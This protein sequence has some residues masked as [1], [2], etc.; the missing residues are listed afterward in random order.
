MEL[1][2]YQYANL[3][4]NSNVEAYE[5]GGTFIRVKFYGTS[6]IYTY[7]YNSAGMENVE[8]AKRLAFS[9]QGLNSYIMRFMKYLYE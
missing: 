4:G 7:S 2:M 8:K 6:K 9:G 5:T 3:G 1:I